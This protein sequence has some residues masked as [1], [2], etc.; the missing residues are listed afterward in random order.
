VLFSDIRHDPS[1]DSV[2]HLRILPGN[3]HLSCNQ[4]M[5]LEIQERSSNSLS[6]VRPVTVA[7]IRTEGPIGTA[8]P[9]AWG[10][11]RNSIGAN[12]RD[13]GAGYGLVFGSLSKPAD[14]Y[15][16]ACIEV[17]TADDGAFTRTLATQTIAGGVHIASA[18]VSSHQAL[19]CALEGLLRDPLIGHGLSVADDRPAIITYARTMM[20]QYSV[21]WSL[22]LNMPLCWATGSQDRAA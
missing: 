21:A 13:F 4:K 6:Y 12:S 10:K 17:P 5:S 11:L 14:M 7:Y 18:A 3:Q 9:Q 19:S 1:K 20:S 2:R 22:T 15:F 8:A 16:D